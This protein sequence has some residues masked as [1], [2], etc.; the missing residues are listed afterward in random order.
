MKD[1][2]VA[3]DLFIYNDLLKAAAADGLHMEADGIIDDMLAMGI[4]PDRQS[5]H[6][7]IYVRAVVTSPW[8]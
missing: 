3:P 4:P 7:L 1:N 5:Y 2:R 8:V 6:H